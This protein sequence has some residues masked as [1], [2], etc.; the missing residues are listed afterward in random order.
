MHFKAR[1]AFSMMAKKSQFSKCNLH[2]DDLKY[3]YKER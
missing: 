1:I 2:F 3:L